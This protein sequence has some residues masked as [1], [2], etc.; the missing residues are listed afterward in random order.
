M[1]SPSLLARLFPRVPHP[2]PVE[3][4]RHVGKLR[5]IVVACAVGYNLRWLMRAVLRLGLKGFLL[6]FVLVQWVRTVAPWAARCAGYT[7]QVHQVKLAA[8]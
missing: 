1:S 2:I 5:L 7:P 6:A 4:Y 8:V 3:V